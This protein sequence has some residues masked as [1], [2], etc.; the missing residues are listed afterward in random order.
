MRQFSS[1]VCR[2]PTL[3]T[4]RSPRGLRTLGNFNQSACDSSYFCNEL[5]VD[6]LWCTCSLSRDSQLSCGLI[7][8]IVVDR[9]YMIGDYL[10]GLH[11]KWYYYELVDQKLE[12]SALQHYSVKHHYCIFNSRRQFDTVEKAFFK[13]QN[14]CE[15]IAGMLPKFESKW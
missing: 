7:R 11:S 1:L 13:L 8:G 12:R 2:S 3:G 15:V 14:I 9:R 6:F 10:A 5:R 4:T